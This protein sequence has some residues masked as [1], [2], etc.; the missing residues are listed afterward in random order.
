MK[1][2]WF[3]LLFLVAISEVSAF[4]EWWE[5]SKAIELDST[6][7]ND[8]ITKN[9][10]TIV[11]FYTKWCKFCKQLAPP[12][13]EFIDKIKLRFN[14]DFLKVARI[15]CDNNQSIPFSYGIYNFPTVLLF[16]NQRAISIFES[17]LDVQ[18]LMFWAL[19]S[20]PH[21][22]RTITPTKV[23]KYL[24]P[25]A[26]INIQQEVQE[27]RMKTP[28][29]STDV[30]HFESDAAEFEKIKNDMTQLQT[31]LDQ[32]EIEILS[33]SS[34][35]SYNIWLKFTIAVGVLGL[36]VLVLFIVIFKRFGKSTKLEQY[37][38]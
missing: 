26:T 3:L 15:E 23:I 21:V 31:K 13:D 12:F 27:E 37:S 32:V 30:H 38:K 34:I 16:S 5:E 20:L 28:E 36:A 1:H 9:D 11:K 22:K 7:F 24:E 25:V 4:K 35:Q 18:S 33:M 2:L 14:T 10:F 19:R 6:N 29:V 8:F 17:N